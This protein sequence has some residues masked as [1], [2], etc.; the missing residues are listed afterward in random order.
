MTSFASYNLNY[1]SLLAVSIRHMPENISLTELPTLLE[2]ERV[3]LDA[4]MATPETNY[5]PTP[6]AYQLL[7]LLAITRIAQVRHCN[8]WLNSPHRDSETDSYGH[9]L[10]RKLVG[11]GYAKWFEVGLDARPGAILATKGARA[12]E[13]SPLSEDIYLSHLKERRDWS[14]EP[15][16]VLASHTLHTTTTTIAFVSAFRWLYE[17]VAFKST[18]P[19]SYLTFPEYNS[20]YLNVFD[21]DGEIARQVKP[22]QLIAIPCYSDTHMTVN[23]RRSGESVRTNLFIEIHCGKKKSN[24]SP[25]AMAERFE[26]YRL[27][28]EQCRRAAHGKTPPINVL[29]IVQS[30][31]ALKALR[32]AARNTVLDHKGRPWNGLYFVSLD[33]IDQALRQPSHLFQPILSSST[34]D[35]LSLDSLFI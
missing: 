30:K 1:S 33:E 29:T 35:E 8:A 5:K 28:R 7:R 19:I 6:S 32:E 16:A 22:D 26:T 18:E 14:K 10:L 23:R 4:P 12:L 11:G 34:K 25:R 2:K 24:K 31:G 3:R 13:S 17:T 21:E 27:Y 15:S 20:T 9:H